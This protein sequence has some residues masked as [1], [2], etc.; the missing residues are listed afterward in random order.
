[1][2]EVKNLCKHYKGAKSYSINGINFFLP[3][4]KVLGL[5]GKNGA[6]KSTTIKSICGIFSF[7][8]G[9]ITV[10]GF[11]IIKDP[12]KAKQSIGYV[13]DNHIT[14]EKLSGREYLEYIGSLFGVNKQ[15]KQNLINRYANTFDIKHALDIQIS[16]YSHGMKQKICLIASLLHQP[17]L[18]VL[19]EPMLGLDP[20][21]RKIVLNFI[22]LYASKGNSVL[23]SSHDI[24]TVKN[25]CDY[26]GIINHGRLVDFIDLS[27][28]KYKTVEKLDKYFMKLTNV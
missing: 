20:Q 28:S 11:D 15:T 25:I 18:W 26:V 2:L 9:K 22:R 24:Y 14:Y 8:K 7:D 6:G 3:K 13:S 4:G 23:F 10:N 16:S 21:T 12:I 19:D 1:M 17:K 27:K 5:I